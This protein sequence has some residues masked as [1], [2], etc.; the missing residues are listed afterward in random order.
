[1]GGDWST[2]LFGCFADPGSFCLAMCGWPFLVGEIFELFKS[3][4]TWDDSS[5]PS[6][7]GRTQK[8][9]VKMVHFGHYRPGPAAQIHFSEIKS[10]RNKVM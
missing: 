9:Q 1:M 8:Q 4:I 5:K 10:E 6:F 2:G 7:K 3:N